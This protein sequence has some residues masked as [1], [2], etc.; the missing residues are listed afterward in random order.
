MWQLHVGFS[1]IGDDIVVNMRGD[2]KE[3]ISHD[4]PE[5]R[6]IQLASAL[7]GMRRLATATTQV[8][9]LI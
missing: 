1:G 9:G 8:A 7:M 4:S 6:D 3:F 5:M 2:E